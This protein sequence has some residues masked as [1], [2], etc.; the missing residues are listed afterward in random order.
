MSNRHPLALTTLRICLG[1][2]FLFEGLGKLAWFADAGILTKMLTGW[3]EAAGPFSQWYIQT[4]CLPGVAMFAR[5]VPL[6]EILAGLALI[7]GAYTPAAAFL[8]LLMV[9]NFHVASGAIFRYE[10]LTNGFGLPV[11]GG[12]L[13]LAIGG[14]HLPASVKR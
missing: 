4:V 3:L 13:A 14:S 11:L 12:L 2:F 7:L 9:L 10:F 1:V 5:I 8:A 6:A